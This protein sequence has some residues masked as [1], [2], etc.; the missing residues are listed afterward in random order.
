V[1]TFV[2]TLLFAILNGISVYLTIPLLDT[3]F[4]GSAQNQ[5]VQQIPGTN[6]ASSILPN[7]VVNLKDDISNTFNHYILSGDKIDVL[8]KIFSPICNPILWLM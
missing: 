8:L 3:L 4:Q 2:F 1:L 5:T 6:Q 7:W